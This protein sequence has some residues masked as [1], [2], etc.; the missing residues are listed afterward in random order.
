MG[1]DG[2]PQNWQGHAH[3]P[4]SHEFSK[5]LWNIASVNRSCHSLAV[6]QKVVFSFLLVR[7]D[8]EL[9]EHIVRPG[10]I[11]EKKARETGHHRSFCHPP[12]H[13][14]HQRRRVKTL[15][16]QLVPAFWARRDSLFARGLVDRTLLRTPQHYPS[17][18]LSLP[19]PTNVLMPLGCDRDRD[20]LFDEREQVCIDRIRG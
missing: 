16:P 12:R 11:L 13:G 8:I 6:L 10:A 19:L 14:G 2:A 3:T 15:R 7:S 1:L 4:P 5:G 20:G 17:S 9:T 18:G